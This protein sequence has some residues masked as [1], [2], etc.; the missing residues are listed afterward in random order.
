M[1]TLIKKLLREAL[2]NEYNIPTLSLTKDIKISNEEKAKVMGLNW[3]DII[4]DQK[5]ESSP[6]QLSVNVPWDSN[7]SEGIA[8]DLQIINDTLFQIHISLS[9][10][11][12]GLG[13]GY[14]IYKALIMTYGHLY[15]G[16]GRRQNTTQVPKIWSKLNSD[17]EITCA[18]NDNGDICVL[19][20]NPDRDTLLGYFNN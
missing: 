10:D 6:I 8:V 20:A 1:K 14:K 4:I 5:T 3:S 15:S 2:T 18:S 7:I 19:N 16:K 11:L 13:L 9:D 12:Q 17:S